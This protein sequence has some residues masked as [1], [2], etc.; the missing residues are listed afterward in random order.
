LSSII[1]STDF[2]KLERFSRKTLEKIGIKNEI[3]RMLIVPKQKIVLKRLEK[4][5]N[6]T[7]ELKNP[8]TKKDGKKIIFHSLDARY[9]LH[10]F[11]EGGISKSLQ[12]RGHNTKMILCGGA[13]SM[14]TTFHRINHPPN[15]WSCKN[16]INFS[17]R[18][19]KI[20]GLNYAV[21]S[22]YINSEKYDKISDEIKTLSVDKCKKYVY[23]HVNVGQHAEISANRFFKGYISS[24]KLYDE[25]LRKELLNAIKATDV[26]EKVIEKEKPDI[27]VTSHGCYSSWGSFAD[28]FTQN[29]IRMCVWATG[30]GNTVT[31]DRHKSDEYFNVYY[32][33]IRK[34]KELNEKESEELENFLNRRIKGREGQVA[35]YGFSEVKEEKLMKE[36]DLDKYKKV[37]AMFPNV[38]WDAAVT[39][40]NIVFD[41]VYDWVSTT[42][43]IFK[44]HPSF[45]LIIKIHPSEV[46]VM[47]SKK[48]MEEYIL[49]EFGS[50]PKNIKII[51]A[52]TEISP[53]SLLSLI[54]YGIVYNGT[55][56]IEM[57]L[58]GTP[59]IVAGKA[60]Y[61]NKGFTYDLKSK[62]GYEKLLFEKNKEVKEK[63]RKAEVYAYFHFIKKFIPRSFTYNNS[64][65]D[66]GWNID[67]LKDF[68]PGND[69]YLDHIC[70]YILNGGVFENW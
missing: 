5:V 45:L 37:C 1:S 13:L 60:H 56:G 62:K 66:I 40:A 9:M 19:Y 15:E 69:K 35:L 39:N 44:K 26:A 54:D 41:S 48:T 51:P 47:E 18:F 7:P 12:L 33:N 21:Y 29:G 17:E 31:I 25:I 49:E 20:V 3:Y 70:E 42:I 23:K 11:L 43:N 4:L 52:D 32:N 16:C 65:L 14:C 22:D 10:T 67:S 8:K 59:V 24:K 64:F 34:R 53:Y 68:C 46:K 38:P 2:K 27:L 6:K 28:Y 58:K 36:F 50:L 30:E 57:V 63:K 55:I 61:G